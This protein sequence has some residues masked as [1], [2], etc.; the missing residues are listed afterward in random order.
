MEDLIRCVRAVEWAA[1]VRMRLKAKLAPLGNGVGKG[2]VLD[3]VDKHFDL[4]RIQ[5]K[6]D[7]AQAKD[8]V[9]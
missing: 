1:N 4:V 6:Q 5:M 2:L 7:A 8:V 9:D 3:R